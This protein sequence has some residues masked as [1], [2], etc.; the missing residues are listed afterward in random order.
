MDEL[1]EIALVFLRLGLLAFGGGIAILPEM[2][3]QVV[4]E[5]QWITQREFVDSYALGRL[6]P[7]PGM[8]LVMFT[9]Y[10]VA[11]IPGALVALF[12]IFGPTAFITVL[13]AAWWDRLRAWPWLTA[14]QRALAPVALGLLA[15][16]GFTLLRS[17][18]QDAIGAVI[19][20]VSL[21]VLWKWHPN[22][23]WVVIVSGL[24]GAVV[25]GLAG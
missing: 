25:Y 13:V 5:H 17:A 23:A 4:V 9:G 21:I 2:E 18:V 16:G 11:G 6:T 3:R 1:P 19:A 8:L 7:G 15:A 12:A 22:P 20:A 14:L 24:V 10:K